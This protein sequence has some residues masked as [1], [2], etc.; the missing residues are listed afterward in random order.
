MPPERTGFASGGYDSEEC[1]EFGTLLPGNAAR[2][3]HV[4]PPGSGLSLLAD[5]DA[6]FGEHRRSGDL[7]GDV[8]QIAPGDWR[9]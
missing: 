4:M 3:D 6:F 8:E 1:I 9:V 2:H 5:L 7:D